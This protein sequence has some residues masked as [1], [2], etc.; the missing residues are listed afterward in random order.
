ML[1]SDT[2]FVAQL[3]TEHGRHKKFD[4][5]ECLLDGLRTETGHR[6][7]W[8]TNLVNPGQWIEAEKATFIKSEMIKSPMG[9]GIAAFETAAEAKSLIDG[10]PLTWRELTVR[11]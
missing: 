6:S 8:V 10:T 3:V 9:G 1:V 4:S 5:I 7:I 2:R 11:L